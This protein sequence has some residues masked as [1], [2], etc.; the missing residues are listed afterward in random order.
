MVAERSRRKE[1]AAR[2]VGRYIGIG[3]RGRCRKADSR[4]CLRQAA[5]TGA[6]AITLYIVLMILSPYFIQD[7]SIQ[8]ERNMV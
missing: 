6:L 5:Q 3:S 1:Q 7:G 8:R 2:Y 4:A